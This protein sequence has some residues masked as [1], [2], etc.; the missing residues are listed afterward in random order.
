MHRHV[1]GRHLH[2]RLYPDSCGPEKIVAGCAMM[3]VM[4]IV[5]ARRSGCS[6]GHRFEL[7]KES[8]RIANW[9]NQ[10]RAMAAEGMQATS[11]LSHGHVLPAKFV[12]G[13][14]VNTAS[15]LSTFVNFW[16]SALSKR[17]RF[18]AEGDPRVKKKRKAKLCF[19]T[20]RSSACGV[21]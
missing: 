17:D 8:S 3:M 20:C 11:K 18:L 4:G 2:G 14:A 5:S 6:G 16:P 21:V 1:D 15:R 12:A 10:R 13:V 7:M 9:Q 19:S